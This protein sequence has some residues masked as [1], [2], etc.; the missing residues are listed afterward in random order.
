MPRS[1]RIMDFIKNWIIKTGERRFTI[2][3]S[4]VVAAIV[5]VF[6]CS[7]SN[8]EPVAEKVLERDLLEI[9]RSGKLVAI[10]RYNSMGYFI[11]KGRPMGYE[12]ELL[13]EL[14]KDLQVDLEI[15][16]PKT[17]PEM[18]SWLNK[19]RGDIVAANLLRTK[20]QGQFA[21]FTESHSTTRQ[22]LVQRKPDNWRDLPRHQLDKQL[23]RNPI[24]LIGKEVHVRRNS[25]H[26]FRLQNLSREIGG[27]INIKTS[28]QGM[29]TEFLIKMVS[30]GLI[31][32]TVANE[33]LVRS[34]EAYYQNIDAKTPVS[35]PQRVS[36][37]VRKSSPELKNFV[38]NWIRDKKSSADPTYY[39]LYVKYFKNRKAF[40]RRMGSE[41]FTLNSTQISP[42]DSLF[43][44]FSENLEW[45]WKLV[46]AQAFQESQFDPNAESWAGALGVMQI[47]PSTGQEL[48]VKNLMDPEENIMAGIKYN[49][50]L[51]SFWKNIPTKEDRI[52]FTLASY[53]AGQGH[54]Q[55]ARRL[56]K[57]YG[58]DPNV[59]DGNV[60]EYLLK[61]SE[62]KYYY[63]DVVKYGFCRGEEP[64]NYVKE[65]MER[66]EIYKRY[67]E[68]YNS[69]A[70]KLSLKG[71]V[72][73]K[74]SN[75]S[76]TSTN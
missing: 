70:Q 41:F 37:A 22:M 55:D 45:D 51:Y 23:V 17:W 7:R 66:Y 47:L 14:A 72:F 60:D 56:A 36:W 76:S 19:E 18:Y 27:D 63:D 42:Y 39:G 40:V 25:P 57:K 75:S 12:Y 50:L 28:P 2:I 16:V 38:D 35:F 6:A 8:Q 53:N 58:K 31:P 48:G 21:T 13:K 1:G 44:K 71:T 5:F 62:E 54:V 52:K 3:A 65:I 29:E 34:F 69:E 74:A 67:E 11:Y 24:D 49:K 43:K 73:S 9:Q 61:K 10:C 26:Y 68:Y 30:E 4:C 46:A 64:F 15:V 33:N 20:E 32:Y 59:W